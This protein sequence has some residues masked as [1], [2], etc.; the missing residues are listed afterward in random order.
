MIVFEILQLYAGVFRK[1]RF[2]Y[3]VYI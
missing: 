1:L 2:T 3:K